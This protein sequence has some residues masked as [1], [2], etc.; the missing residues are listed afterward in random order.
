MIAV[1]AVFL[2]H[3]ATAPKTP[4][5]SASQAAA[6]AGPGDGLAAASRDSSAYDPYPDCPTC[7]KP[8]QGGDSRFNGKDGIVEANQ[9]VADAI[10]SLLE[11][12][13]DVLDG[14]REEPKPPVE[15]RSGNRSR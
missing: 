1:Q 5:D 15:S 6:S 8:T 7:E 10:V 14:F 9:R 3:C 13:N 4:N 2:L 12:V 11:F